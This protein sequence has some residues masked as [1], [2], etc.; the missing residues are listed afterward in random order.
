MAAAAANNDSYTQLY[1][2]AGTYGHAAD[3]TCVCMDE[4]CARVIL[5]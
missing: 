5:G 3:G 4:A 2:S 1:D